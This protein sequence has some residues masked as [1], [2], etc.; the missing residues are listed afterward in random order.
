MP[1]GGLQSDGWE[2]VRTAE[3]SWAATKLAERAA[4]RERRVNFMARGWTREMVE[5]KELESRRELVTVSTFSTK[6][7][8]LGRPFFDR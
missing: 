5:E 7:E 4:A 1:R 8:T 2:E 3:R 6:R